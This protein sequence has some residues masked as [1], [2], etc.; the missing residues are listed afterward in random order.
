MGMR[1]VGRVPLRIRLLRLGF[2]GALAGDCI[3]GVG[4]QTTQALLLDRSFMVGLAM[5]L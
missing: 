1:S 5:P 4:T 2:V 3:L